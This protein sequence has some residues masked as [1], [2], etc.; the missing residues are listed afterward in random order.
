MEEKKEKKPLTMKSLDIKLGE[1]IVEVDG[2]KNNNTRL[3]SLVTELTG[4]LKTLRRRV[5]TLERSEP[6]KKGRSYEDVMGVTTD[7]VPP[8]LQ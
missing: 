7:I 3:D 4:E 5:A 8:W 2:L 6:K 1:L